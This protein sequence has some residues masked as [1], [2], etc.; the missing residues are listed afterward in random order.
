MRVNMMSVHRL[1]RGVMEAAVEVWT[2][3]TKL[4]TAH[5]GV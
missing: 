4:V 5:N 3:V 1:R 2:Q